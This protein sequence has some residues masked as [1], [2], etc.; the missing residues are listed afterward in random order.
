[1]RNVRVLVVDDFQQWREFVC[2]ALQEVANFEVVGIALDGPEAIDKTALLRP[3]LVVL[4]IA[5]P[6]MNGIEVARSLR[7]VSPESTI[8]FLTENR[9]REVIEECFRAGASGYVVKSSARDDL[10]SIINAAL[11]RK[12]S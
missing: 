1:M 2:A 10:L 7:G 5:L 11:K 6:T 9:S 4:D 8:V 3:D 12:H